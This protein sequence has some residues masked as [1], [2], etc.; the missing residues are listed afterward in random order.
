MRRNDRTY[1]VAFRR[2][3]EGKTDYHARLS[4]LKS[5]K[6]RLVVR[7][8]LKNIFVQ[9]TQYQP[10]GDRIIISA[11]STELKKLGWKLHRGNTL[12]AY[13]VG[14]LIGE[15]AK[16]ANVKEVVLDIGLQ[17]SAK[18]SCLYAVAK[19]AIDAGLKV[20]CDKEILPSDDRI[21]GKH[22]EAYA[23]ALATDKGAYQRQFA[24]YLKEGVNPGDLSKHIQ[25]IKLKIAKG[26]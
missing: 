4:T 15:K 3:R 6:P 17:Q 13:F 8:S 24:A 10:K 25:E 5:N 26:V 21:Q 20:P 1:T 23:K 7:K 16:K 11:H 2:K 22:I 19:G 18:G 9:I 12:T 14:V